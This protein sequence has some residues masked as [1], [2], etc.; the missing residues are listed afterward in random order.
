M[1]SDQLRVSLYVNLSAIP[2]TAFH[3]PLSEPGHQATLRERA[4]VQSALLQ[5]FTTWVK[6]D[7]VSSI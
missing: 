3:P 6:L 4:E 2:L 5:G 1:I 7:G